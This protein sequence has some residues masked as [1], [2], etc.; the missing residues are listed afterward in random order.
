MRWFQWLKEQGS[1]RSISLLFLM[2]ILSVTPSAARLSWKL[3]DLVNPV[4]GELAELTV[5]GISGGKRVVRSDSAILNKGLADLHLLGRAGRVTAASVADYRDLPRTTLQLS[6]VGVIFSTIPAKSVA[7]INE[8]NSATDADL[9]GVGDKLPGNAV[10]TE[11]HLDRVVLRRAGSFETLSLNESSPF[12]I[13]NKKSINNKPRL[14]TPRNRNFKRSSQSPI[15]PSGDGANLSI[16]REYLNHWLA[17]LDSLASE[18]GVEVFSEGGR[19]QGYKLT[20]GSC[21]ELLGQL[22]LRDGDVLT[23]VNGMPLRN[24]GEVMKAYVKSKN[25]DRVQIQIVRDGKRQN[26]EYFID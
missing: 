26:S 12:V 14:R 22:G 7:I 18:I 3:F 5:A 13:R 24:V 1:H 2:L 15:R 16:D 17:N 21:S 23:E 25:A 9:Y 6:L 20:G 4:K 8:K 10:L 11:I 19:Q